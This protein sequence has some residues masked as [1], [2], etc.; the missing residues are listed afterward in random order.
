MKFFIVKL[1]YAS[2]KHD[3]SLPV[4]YGFSKDFV[5]FSMFP[6]T[7]VITLYRS[8]LVCDKLTLV[9]SAIVVILQATSGI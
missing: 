2:E 3:V 6:S 8:I 5:S 4:S 9:Y 1:L 7:T